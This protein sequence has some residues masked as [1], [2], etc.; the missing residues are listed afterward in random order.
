MWQILR[1]LDGG[2]DSGSLEGRVASAAPPPPPRSTPAAPSYAG[3]ETSRWG[4][5]QAG[6]EALAPSLLRRQMATILALVVAGSRARVA[7]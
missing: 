3:K 7:A 2:G 6:L 5:S 1:R 4:D